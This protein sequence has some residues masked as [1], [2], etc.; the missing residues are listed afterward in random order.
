MGITA[1]RKWR[2]NKSISHFKLSMLMTMIWS[3]LFLKARGLA[4]HL[5]AS[6]GMVM[7][8]ILITM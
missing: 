4:Q 6:L 7:G 8:V 2:R 5:P 3:F 1:N